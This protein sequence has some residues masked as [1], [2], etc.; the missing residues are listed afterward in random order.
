MNRFK[1]GLFTTIVLTMLL[2]A[3][4]A[5]ATK[6]V[7]VI[8]AVSEQKA[9]A[10]GYTL[11]YDGINEGLQTAGITPIYQWVELD[12]AASE[13]QKAAFGAKAVEKARQ[14]KPDLIITLSDECVKHVGMKI[15]D[16]PIVFTYVFGDPKILGL[17]KDNI[18]G[19]TRGSYAADIW[20]MTHKLTGAKTVSL[21]SKQSL[22]MAGVRQYLFAG[23]D[24]LEA[25]SGVRFKEMYLVDTFEEWENTVKNFS[26]DFIYLADT[27][28]VIKGDREL[29]R[30][31]TT[32]WTVEN[33]K[34]PV[35]GASEVDVKAG[36]LFSIVTSEKAMGMKA[37]EVALKVLDGTA[38]KDIPYVASTKGKLVFNVKTAEQYKIDIPY[39]ILSTAEAIYEE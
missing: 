2:L 38:P 8:S 29:S 30:P 35:I 24:K 28:R 6:N 1:I 39:E 34:V 3:G 13:E 9:A 23:A 31:E 21:I 10:A 27:S 11:V 12:I 7:V 4:N 14:A 36:A 19:V 15:D 33:A 32:R 26:E 25:A 37:A 16:I 5:L 20:S 18:T 17:P 22:S